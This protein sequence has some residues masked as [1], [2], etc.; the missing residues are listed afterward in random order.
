V[1]KIAVALF[2][3][4]PTVSYA[5]GGDVLSLMW[6]ELILLIVVLLS[7]AF[8]NLTFAGKGVVLFTYASGA[9]VPWWFTS[10]WP[11]SDNLM[12]INTIDI[13][14]PFILWLC[15]FFVA[16]KKFAQKTTRKS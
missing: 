15:A 3:L 7:V 16:R 4:W 9:I 5:S 6:L 14:S 11:Y 8:G 10:S 12:L 2:T 13:G 1:H